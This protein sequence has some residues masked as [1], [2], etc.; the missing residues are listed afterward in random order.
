MSQEQ[1]PSAG[2]ILVG[3]DGSESARHALAWAAFIASRQ[4]KRVR[5]V[6]CYHVPVL[7]RPDL[8]GFTIDRSIDEVLRDTH[9]GFIA[10]ARERIAQLDPSVGFDGVVVEGVAQVALPRLA[11]RDDI[12]VVGSLGT[13]GFVADLMGTVATAVIRHAT[14]PVIVVP[15]EAGLPHGDRLGSV[16]VGVDGSASSD[17]ALR[18]AYDLAA[19]GG[20]GE[21]R[22]VHAWETSPGIYMEVP[23]VPTGR[24]EQRGRNTLDHAVQRLAE[25]T[26]GLGQ[27]PVTKILSSEVSRVALTEASRST[28]LL[29]I[30]SHGHGVVAR[31]LLGSI[32]RSVVE[33]AQCAV[34]VIR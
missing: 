32:S 7:N 1:T 9:N 34:A 29:V 13:T 12:L 8:I 22:V 4:H 25:E 15:G 23:E 18:W 10:T 16:T 5:A 6:S 28:D 30:G 24:Y 20:A 19:N 26:G 2:T 11:G 27:L 31:M 21:L 33:H 3:V 17:V 14:C